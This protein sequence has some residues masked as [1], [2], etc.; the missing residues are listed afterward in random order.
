[1]PDPEPLLPNRAGE[2]TDEGWGA[3]V[4]E[5]ADPH[6]AHDDWL[7]NQRPPHH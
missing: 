5:E 3:A 2:D 4:P 1:V 7:R 6:A